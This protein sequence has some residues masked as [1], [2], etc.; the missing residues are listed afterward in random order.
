MYFC[1]IKKSCEIHNTA[2]PLLF[3]VTG[4]GRL[5]RN[6]FTLGHGWRLAEFITACSQDRFMAKEP[7]SLKS[8]FYHTKQA[9]NHWLRK[10]LFRYYQTEFFNKG[11]FTSWGRNPGNISHYHSICYYSAWGASFLLMCTLYHTSTDA[12]CNQRWIEFLLIIM[13]IKILAESYK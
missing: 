1:S 12:K 10:V 3:I 4:S 7:C 11:G 8:A 6:Y 9:I 5:R 2:F 13:I